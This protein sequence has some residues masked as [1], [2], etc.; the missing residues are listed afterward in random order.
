MQSWVGALALRQNRGALLDRGL[1]FAPQ[2]SII[3]V[4]DRVRD[5]HKWIVRQARYLGHGLGRLHKPIRND[6]RGRDA[7]FLD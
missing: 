2:D 1:G 4:T 5:H 6:R 3:V 7:D